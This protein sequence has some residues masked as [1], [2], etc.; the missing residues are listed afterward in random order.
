MRNMKTGSK[1]LCGFGAVILMSII[2]TLVLLTGLKQLGKIP[3][4]MYGGVYTASN[5]AWALRRNMVDTEKGLYQLIVIDD[6]A[7]LQEIEASI[8]ED[9]QNIKDAMGGLKSS[10]DSETDRKLYQQLESFISESDPYKQEIM[11]LVSQNKKEEAKALLMEKYEPIFEE[12]NEL[13][14]EIYNESSRSGSAFVE[15]ARNM[16]VNIQIIGV[17]LVAIGTV[18]SLIITKRITVAIVKPIKQVTQAAQEMAKGH[19]N[20]CEM[21]TYESRDEVG[22]LADCMRV[23]MTNLGHY[24]DE[25]SHNL[26]R[27]SEGDLTVDRNSITDYLGDF[28]SIKTSFVKIL[29]NFNRTLTEIERSAGQ[30][31][32]GSDQVASASQALSQGASEQ[33][34]TVEKLTM[35]VENISQQVTSNANYANTANQMSIDVGSRLNESNEQMMQMV[36]A[37]NRINNSSN[38]INKIIKAIEDIAFQTNILALNAAVEAARAGEAGKGFAVVADEVRSL[39]SKSG[40]AAKETTKLIEDSIQAVQAGTEI[41]DVTAGKIADVA[42]DADRMVET[43]SKISEASRQQAQSIEEVTK[44]MEQISSVVQTNSATAEESAAASEE[45]S[46][47]AQMLDELVSRFQL[48]KG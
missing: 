18:V 16:G 9:E 43:I 31:N 6:E 14:K 32:S 22:V 28:V 21:I 1:I 10:L 13:A 47:Q 23:T 36:A 29:T 42:K 8:L 3:V 11:S 30:V 4:Q 45:L 17:V 24:V 40:E 46:G 26:Q 12:A 15:S 5:C 44:S 25:I 39:A 35:T 19:M 7:R 33:A 41:A 37:M 20:A 38:E 2:V 48:Y 27:I 34:D